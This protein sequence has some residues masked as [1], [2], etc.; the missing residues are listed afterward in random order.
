M[1]LVP[2][3][4]LGS[5]DA[6]GLVLSMRP[7]CVLKL[8]SGCSGPRGGGSASTAGHCRR[9]SPVRSAGHYLPCPAA[10][11]GCAEQCMQP[12]P[13]PPA[14]SSPPACARH[15]VP[16]TCSALSVSRNLAVNLGAEHKPSDI[17]S[18]G[19]YGQVVT[20]Y[21]FASNSSPQ[22]DDLSTSAIS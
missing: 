13:E 9:H 21:V 18:Q 17:K 16:L 11:A 14:G 12:A 19:G 22:Q 1:C 10:S 6:D 8:T 15:P 20:L 3:I 2:D 4:A 7:V 5:V